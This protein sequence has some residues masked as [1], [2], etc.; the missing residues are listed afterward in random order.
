[1]RL[2]ITLLLLSE[3]V[4]V[5]VAQDDRVLVRVRDVGVVRAIA[6][7]RR[8]AR[9]DGQLAQARAATASGAD[10]RDVEF[11]VEV[12]SAQNRRR[13]AGH[14]PAYC[15]RASAYELT[16]RQT[17]LAGLACLRHVAVLLAR[18]VCAHSPGIAPPAQP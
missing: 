8:L 6:L 2:R 12:L 15:E 9:H 11:A 16:P 17:R 13:S 1:L 5:D 3:R 7:A 10:E 14:Q 18:G 4:L